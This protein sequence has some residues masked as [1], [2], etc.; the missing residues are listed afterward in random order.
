MAC[1]PDRQ[2]CVSISAN[3]IQPLVLKPTSMRD[4]SHRCVSLP[5]EVGQTGQAGISERLSFP[6]SPA[7][8]GE[9]VVTSSA[10]EGWQV[11]V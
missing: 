2:A 1:L 5:A 3:A 7:K 6:L 10:V 4:E 8:K 9:T 11:L